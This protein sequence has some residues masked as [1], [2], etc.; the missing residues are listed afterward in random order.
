MKHRRKHDTIIYTLALLGRREIE[1]RE[2]QTRKPMH[3]FRLMLVQVFAL[4]SV[5]LF[6][7]S[8]FLPYQAHQVKLNRN[9]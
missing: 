4:V 6:L 1:K 5:F 7:S 3:V 9:D 8:Q 2:I